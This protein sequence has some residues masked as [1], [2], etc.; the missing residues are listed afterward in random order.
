MNDICSKC[1][2]PPDLCVCEI[3]AKES[4]KIRVFIV[5]KKFNKYYTIVEGIDTKS[6]DL[7]EAAKNL[8]SKLACGGAIKDGKIE[9]QGDHR[10][11]VKRILVEMGFAPETIEVR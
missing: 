10:Q 4:Q 1:G 9:L 6:I 5:N 3:I 11:A 7:K 2:L 8:K